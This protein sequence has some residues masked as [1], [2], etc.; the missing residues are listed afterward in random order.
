LKIPEALT[1]E[2]GRKPVPFVS[3][4][5]T[6]YQHASY[7]ARCLD[8]I[9]MQECPFTYEVLLG[10]DDSTDGTRA[11][12]QRYAEAHPDR[13]RL[14]LHRRDQMI[15]IDGRPTGRHNFLNNLRHATG[16]Y[17]CHVDGDDAW[18]DPLRLRI[19]VEKME[20]EP[21]L[22]LAFHN[23]MNQWDDGRQE[24]YMDPAIAKP[25]F[26]LQELAA[27]NFIPT[28]GVIWRWNGLRELPEAFRTAPFGD[29]GL[30]I[31]FALQ[32][33]I[34]YVDRIMSVRQV[35]EGGVMSTM[36]GLRTCRGIA[37]A[38]EVMHKQA[39][40]RIGK[41]A[42]DR[43]ALQITNGFETSISRNEREM[44]SWFLKHAAKVPGGRIPVRLRLR[45]WLLLH[46]PKFMQRYAA[47]RASG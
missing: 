45:W 36:S 26:T 25:R 23:A 42:L 18:T 41:A 44:A 19:M 30:N 28:S 3:I 21:D 46:F 5:V 39:G 7:L 33:A 9:L 11:I 20:A 15:R 12:A 34:G 13:I 16:R 43:W 4:S 2:E 24:P 6:A 14:F 31:H 1:P 29:W 37:L 10:E 35:H 22:A 40:D 8:G 27:K 47:M 38:Y 17:L 32:G